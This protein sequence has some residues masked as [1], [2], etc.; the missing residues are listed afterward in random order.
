MPGPAPT[1][2]AQ[3]KG[4]YTDATRKSVQGG[5]V[6]TMSMSSTTTI[7]GEE[8]GDEG[9]QALFTELSKDGGSTWAGPD[10]SRVEAPLE[11]ASASVTEIRP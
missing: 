9:E 8:T 2:I 6:G 3:R 10:S 5:N 4:E 11:N 7:A 1:C